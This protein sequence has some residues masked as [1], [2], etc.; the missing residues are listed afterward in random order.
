L[1]G[2]GRLIS[3]G[4]A[5]LIPCVACDDEKPMA[6]DRAPDRFPTTHWSRVLA[7]GDR[8]APEARQA[9]ADLCAAYWYPLYAFIRRK[10]HGP[11]EALDLTQDFFARLVERHI[12]AAADPGKG[13]FRSFLLAD[14]THFLAH[15]RDHD[16][17]IRR[18]GGFAPV[19]IDARDAEGRY[20]R[21]PAHNLTP[22]RLF[23]Q[24]WAVALLAEVVV[25]LRQEYHDS[26]REATFEVLK[27]VLTES[28]RAV[29]QVDLAVRLGTSPGAVQVAIHRL[30][31][32]YRA[33]VREAIAATIGDE[34]D[35]EAEI[36]ELFAALGS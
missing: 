26:G 3:G 17:A 10:G 14:C 28:P 32:R 13:R 29:S 2:R 36:R 19:S 35:P 15:R 20:L 12:V 31:K 33:L 16:R 34:V 11:E 24:D 4:I 1:N 8:A 9:L 27:V 22:E 5:I 30:R 23:E 7:A 18:G 21:E 6:E 25:R